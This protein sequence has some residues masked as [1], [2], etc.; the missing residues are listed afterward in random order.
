M[1]EWSTGSGSLE[2]SHLSDQEIDR[3]LNLGHPFHLNVQLLIHI[4]EMGHHHVDNVIL[5]KRPE[6]PW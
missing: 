2:A 6:Y 3:S 1:S 4:V 5:V